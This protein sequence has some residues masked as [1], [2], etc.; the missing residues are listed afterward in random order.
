MQ[1]EW[2]GRAGHPSSYGLLGGAPS[3][4]N[5]VGVWPSDAKFNDS[6][7]SGADDVRWGLPSEYERAILGAVESEPQRVVV[8]TA[9]HGAIGSSS[10]IFARLAKLLSR[11]LATDIPS[12]DEDVWRLVDRIWNETT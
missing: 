2:A 4:K 3:D 12:E 1:V 10:L 9:A 11:L 8:G 5:R 6:L 7:A